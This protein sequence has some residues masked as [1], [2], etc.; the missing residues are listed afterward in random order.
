[1]ANH[2][3]AAFK[4]FRRRNILRAPPPTA[5]GV[6]GRTSVIGAWQLQNKITPTDEN[7]ISR[8]GSLH[9]VG[10]F[11]PQTSDIDGSTGDLDTEPITVTDPIG[12]T[13]LRTDHQPASQEQRQAKAFGDRIQQ[14][15]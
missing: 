14:C 1:M 2:R 13:R 6:A 10:D 8:Q 12:A 7:T 15:C 3:A 9:G 5:I 4:E 11:H